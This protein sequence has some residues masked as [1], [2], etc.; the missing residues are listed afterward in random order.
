V[1]FTKW[2][3]SVLAGAACVSVPTL[4][5]SACWTVG[6]NSMRWGG[7]GAVMFFVALGLTVAAIAAWDY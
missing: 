4:W 2:A 5:I 3:L 1:T 7:T 6:D